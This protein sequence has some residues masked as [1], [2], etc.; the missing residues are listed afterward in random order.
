MLSRRLLTFFSTELVQNPT[1]TPC[2]KLVLDKKYVLNQIL[3]ML[4]G[5]LPT[6]LSTENVQNA[7]FA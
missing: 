5:G 2:L 6:I 1:A 3:G 4:T 7:Q